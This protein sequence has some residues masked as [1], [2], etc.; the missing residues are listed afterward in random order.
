MADVDVREN[1]NATLGRALDIEPNSRTG[2][3]SCISLA[4]KRASRRGHWLWLIGLA[5]LGA[6]AQAQTPGAQ[7]DSAALMSE[8]TRQVELA[9]SLFSG[10]RSERLEAVRLYHQAAALYR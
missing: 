7:R 3:M 2:G 9:N 6:R 5:F 4:E 8:A 1:L 10:T